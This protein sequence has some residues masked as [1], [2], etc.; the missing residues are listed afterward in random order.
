VSDYTP[1]DCDILLFRRWGG[2]LNHAAI[3]FVIGGELWAYEA[4]PPRAHSIRWQNYTDGWIRRAVLG[5]A[6]MSV[7][8]H[9]GI[10]RVQRIILLASYDGLEGTRYNWPVNWWFDADR[11]INCLEF[12]A[13]G[14]KDAFG[15]DIYGDV[16]TGRIGPE[17]FEQVTLGL[18]WE[19]LLT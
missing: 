15:A 19:E 6:E 7:L 10:S 12:L 9:P 11:L 8:T 2:L 13:L 3:V 5:G 4:W 18:G 1:R 17:L 14:Q 16:P